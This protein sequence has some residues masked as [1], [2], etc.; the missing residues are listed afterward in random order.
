[1][2]GGMRW[3]IRGVGLEDDEQVGV[4]VCTFDLD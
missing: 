1:M 4:C 3:G 2:M